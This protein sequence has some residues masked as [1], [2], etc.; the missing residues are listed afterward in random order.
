MMCDVVDRHRPV[1][2]S[3]YGYTSHLIIPQHTFHND[4]FGS[5]VYLSARI[6]GRPPTK[7]RIKAS[8]SQHSRGTDISTLYIMTLREVDPNSCVSIIAIKP[9]EFGQSRHNPLQSLQL[10]HSTCPLCFPSIVLP[11]LEWVSFIDSDIRLPFCGTTT[12]DSLL[13]VH[14]PHAICLSAAIIAISNSHTGHSMHRSPRLSLLDDRSNHGPLNQSPKLTS[15][16]PLP[17]LISAVSQLLAP[18]VFLRIETHRP[19]RYCRFC[20]TAVPQPPPV[21]NEGHILLDCYLHVPLNQ[22]RLNLLDSSPMP[23]L[24]HMRTTVILTISCSIMYHTWN[25]Q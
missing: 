4:H 15:L 11:C 9:R 5:P 8:I 3:I 13:A 25:Q 22:P 16:S 7:K 10:A 1:R 18:E 6:P 21:E 24:R 23:Y 12:R 20:E 19:P 2:P 14:Q 17:D